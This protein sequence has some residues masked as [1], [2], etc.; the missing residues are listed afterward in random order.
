[1]KNIFL[2][3][4]LH[5]ISYSFCSQALCQNRALKI[6]DTCPD[7]LLP[8]II[9]YPSSEARISDFKGKILILDFWATWCAPCVGLIPLEDSLQKEF[10][11]RIQILPVTSQDKNTVQ[12]FLNSVAQYK[13]VSMPSVT[14]DKELATLFP[15]TEIPHYVWIGNDSKVIAIT[16]FSQLQ[17]D[18]IRNLLMKK[19]MQSPVKIDAEKVIDTET[20]MFTVGNELL[21]GNGVHFDRTPDSAVLYHSVFTNYLAGFGCEQGTTTGRITCKNAAIGDLYRVAAG[22]LK[23]V[24]LEMNSTIWETA[25]DDVK[26]RSDSAVLAH[27]KS[28]EENRDWIRQYTYCYELKLP[29]RLDDKKYELMLD[30]LNKY[31]GAMYHITGNIERR[32][33][34]CLAMIK[35]GAYAPPSNE[36]EEP[37][38]AF[39][40]FHLQLKNAA[41]SDLLGLLSIHLANLP[42]MINETN[43]NVKRNYDLNCN[44]SDL[45]SVNKSLATFGLQLVEKLTERDMIV[46]KDRPTIE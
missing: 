9:N 44:L 21:T 15:H 46:I 12:K 42:P 2:L 41:T 14:G 32:R 40:Q 27:T 35:T 26:K 31:F 4:C 28:L 16:S 18:T 30:D 24:N 7:I 23:L 34:K 43:D 1:M 39:D 36:T 29:A 13:N 22:H 45:N 6:G 38:N 5:C 33:V 37:G 10:K 19:V 11:G 25:N 17:R 20:P 8:H 3:L